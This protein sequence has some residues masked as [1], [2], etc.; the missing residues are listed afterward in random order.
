MRYKIELA[1]N[2]AIYHGWQIQPNAITVQ[3]ILQEAFSVLL[4]EKI[5]IVGCG[6]TDTGV[7]AKYFVA[8]FDYQTDIDIFNFLKKINSFLPRDIVIHSLLSVN[9]D[10]HARFSAVAR[11]YKYYIITKKDPFNNAYSWEVFFNL[12]IDKMR[13]AANMLIQYTDFTSFSKLHTDVITNNCKI[14]SVNIE[15]KKHEIVFTITADRF[16]RNM[17]RAIV[18]TLVEVGKG[19]TSLKQFEDIIKSKNRCNAGQSAPAKALFLTNV[20]Y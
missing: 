5:E 16:L 4:C 9:Q 2:G 17:V 14:K 7:H 19:K 15:Q 11:T 6:R 18:G 12:D 10:F 3:Q 8:H 20:E 1:Y 13:V